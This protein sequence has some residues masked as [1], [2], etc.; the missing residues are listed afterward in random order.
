[1]RGFWVVNMTYSAFISSKIFQFVLHDIDLSNAI[2]ME[3]KWQMHF[4]DSQT[5]PGM[6]INM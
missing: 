3:G 1:M 6:C 2:I 4:E 5:R